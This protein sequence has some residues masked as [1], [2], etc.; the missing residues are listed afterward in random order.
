ME[1]RA[2]ILDTSR[3]RGGREGA[4][5]KRYWFKEAGKEGTNSSNSTEKY[6]VSV[7]PKSPKEQPTFIDLHIFIENPRI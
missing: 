6:Y 2:E 5:R 4:K 1:R 3:F 7:L